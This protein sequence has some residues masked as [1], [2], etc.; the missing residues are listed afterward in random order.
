[1]L[2]LMSFLFCNSVSLVGHWFP[3]AALIGA[4]YTGCDKVATVALLTV[5]VAF[6]GAVGAGYQINHVDI[7]AN[8]AGVLMGFCNGISNLAGIAAPYVAGYI[9]GDDE[10]NS[11]IFQHMFR[12]CL[13]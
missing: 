9:V 7:A 2:K 4:A 6:S 11:D 1:M 3:A 12:N 13:F 8:H 10:V 5:A